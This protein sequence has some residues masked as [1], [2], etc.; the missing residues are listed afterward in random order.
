[1]GAVAIAEQWRRAAVEAAGGESGVPGR[2][3][4]R[5]QGSA[6]HGFWGPPMEN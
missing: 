5:R 2:T 4:Q 6:T 3:V 1:V